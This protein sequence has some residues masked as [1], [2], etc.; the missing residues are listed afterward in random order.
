MV[1]KCLRAASRRL[2]GEAHLGT[3]PTTWEALAYHEKATCLP[4]EKP[5]EATPR[6]PA[7]IMHADAAL[8]SED[9]MGRAAQKGIRPHD[10]GRRPWRCL[11]CAQ[12]TFPIQMLPIRCLFLVGTCLQLPPPVPPS[13]ARDEPMSGE[14]AGVG[15]V[16]ERVTF[17]TEAHAVRGGPC[18]PDDKGAHG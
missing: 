17:V 12:T 2:G 11:R 5:L 1:D 10:C 7:A 3:V 15:R 6:H 9:H 4:R 8:R 18:V 13:E 14:W 16:G